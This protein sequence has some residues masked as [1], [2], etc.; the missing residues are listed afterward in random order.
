MQIIWYGHS[1]FLI[2]TSIGKRILIEPFNNITKYNNNF[3]KCDLIITNSNYNNLDLSGSNSDTRIFNEIGTF[4]ILDLELEG[5]N[6]FQ[7][8]C[9][10]IKR[11]PNIIYI[12]KD[13]QYSLCHLGNLGHIPSH[14]VLEKIKNIDILLIPI[15]GNFTLNGFDAAKL[16][17]LI[18]P[19]YIIPMQYKTNNSSLYLDD[20]KNFII[21]V[22][23]V[24][25]LNSNT[26]NTSDLQFNCQSECLLLSSQYTS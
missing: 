18:H 8:K 21:S 13:N 26:I 25:K 5:L 22:K 14:L 19:K 10:G 9:N 17:K 2:K 20:P 15:G 23:N 1:C 12:I 4:H 6:S 16:C 11:G 24:R 3:P 7:D